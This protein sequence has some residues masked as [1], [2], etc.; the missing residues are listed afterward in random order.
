MLQTQ[1]AA[2]ILSALVAKKY[3]QVLKAAS[4]IPN[5]SVGLSWSQCKDEIITGLPQ[6]GSTIRKKNLD[7]Y[8]C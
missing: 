4:P 6:T 5:N 7:R 2:G 3:P 1:M 8:T